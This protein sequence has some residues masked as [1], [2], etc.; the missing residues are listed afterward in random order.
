MD[1]LRTNYG[2]YGKFLCSFGTKEKLQ[3]SVVRVVGGYSEGTGFFITKDKVI[4]NFHVIADEPTPKIIRSIS[5]ILIG[6]AWFFH[7]FLLFPLSSLIS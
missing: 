3:N 2:F 7:Y 4:T 6:Q 1:Y 5:Y